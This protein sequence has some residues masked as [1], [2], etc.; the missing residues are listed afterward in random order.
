MSQSQDDARIDIEVAV[1]YGNREISDGT[2]RA[3]A[4]QWHDG[5]TVALSFTSTGTMLG[6][7]SEVYRACGGDGFEKAGRTQQLALSMLGTY[8]QNRA[9]RGPVDGW[10]DLW[11]GDDAR[12][13]NLDR[14]E[15]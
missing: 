4:S 8:L 10:G 7:P 13:R 3:I 5:S 1:R 2:A 15:R 14:T 12:S 6:D 9:D 11:I